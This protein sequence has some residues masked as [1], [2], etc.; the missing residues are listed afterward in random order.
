MVV[1]AAFRDDQEPELWQERILNDGFRHQV[2]K[3]YLRAQQLADEIGGEVLYDGDWFVAA[4]T[5]LDVG[6]GTQFLRRK[7]SDLSSRYCQ[8]LD[9]VN[10]MD[11]G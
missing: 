4:R 10:A 2:Y 8:W 11:G 5:S 7:P 1:D 3:R 6:V 9:R